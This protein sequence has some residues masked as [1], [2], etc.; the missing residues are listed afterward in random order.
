MERI[1]E[2]AIELPYD[3]EIQAG[4][5]SGHAK[6]WHPDDA[7]DDAHPVLMVFV[8]PGSEDWARERIESSLSNA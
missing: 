2:G 6:V 1:V 3:S 8:A 4:N 5:W 7:P